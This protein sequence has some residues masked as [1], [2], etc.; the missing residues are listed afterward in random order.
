M[1]WFNR[2]FL[3]Y[4]GL[5]LISI[6]FGFLVWWKELW[7]VYRYDYQEMTQLYLDSQLVDPVGFRREM[8]DWD[9]YAFAGYGYVTTGDISLVN[10][11]HPPFGK[12]LLGWSTMWFGNPHVAQVLMGW[13]VI[14]LVY[15]V[16]FRV[17]DTGLQWNKTIMTTT[18]LSILVT[19]LFLLDGLFWYQIEFTL[20]DLGLLMFILLFFYLGLR[21]NNVGGM[22]WVFGVVL[23]LS[24]GVKFGVPSVLLFASY[25]LYRM[26]S[27]RSFDIFHLLNVGLGAMATYVLLYLPLVLNQG[28]LGLVDIHIRALRLH[29]SHIPDYPWL[30]PLRVMVFNQWPIWWDSANP[31]I[32]VGQWNWLWLVLA[33]VGIW[34]V[35][36]VIWKMVS[37]LKNW[38]V[39][40]QHRGSDGLN[41]LFLVSIFTAVYFLFINTR[42]FFP[43]YLLLILPFLYLGLVVWVVRI[44]KLFSKMYGRH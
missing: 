19:V 29:L 37:L 3:F 35:V 12:Y 40:N 20:L 16:S 17:L 43:S 24:A 14:V 25:A 15:F 26:A 1:H 5:V 23:G 13:V 44:V 39:Y 36:W 18:L 42:L 27:T 32:S 34:V 6:F 38:R 4:L 22:S 28:L 10:F 30:V 33:G 41:S 21:F 31:I 8:F 7:P 9:L 2:S 11:E